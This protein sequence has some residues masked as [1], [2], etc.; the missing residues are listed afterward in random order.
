V[1][2][3]CEHAREHKRSLPGVNEESI[4]SGLRATVCSNASH[5]G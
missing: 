1:L 4:D 5:G 2:D 3:T